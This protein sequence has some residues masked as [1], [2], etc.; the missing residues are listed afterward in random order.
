[1]LTNNT[2]NHVERSEIPR[3]GK[4]LMTNFEFFPLLITVQ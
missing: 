3:S 1:M 4:L 2:F